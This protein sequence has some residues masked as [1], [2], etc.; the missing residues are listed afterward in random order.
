MKDYLQDFHKHKEVFLYFPAIKL[1]KNA[2]KQVSKGLRE[3]HQWRLASDHLY[4]QT[5]AKLQ[6]HQQALRLETEELV[7]IFLTT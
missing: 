2:V 3:E 1:V 5:L 4:Q 7:H 6:K